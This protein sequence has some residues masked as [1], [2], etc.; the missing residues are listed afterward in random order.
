MEDL[1]QDTDHV[2]LN[3]DEGIV[4]LPKTGGD[5]EIV[6]PIRSQFIDLVVDDTHVYWTDQEAGTV[7]RVAKP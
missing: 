4:R 3:T 6:V 1:E 7:L 2:Y 5:P